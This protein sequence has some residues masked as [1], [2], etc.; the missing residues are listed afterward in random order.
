MSILMGIILDRGIHW[1]GQG[2][3]VEQILPGAKKF[4]S[5]N[6]LTKGSRHMLNF[7]EQQPKPNKALAKV[8]E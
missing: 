3:N 5:R 4:Y 2:V 1:L 7:L 8:Y 6:S